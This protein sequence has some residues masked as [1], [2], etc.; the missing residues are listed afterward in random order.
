MDHQDVKPT[1]AVGRTP[2][3]P[4]TLLSDPVWKPPKNSSLKDGETEVL[5]GKGLLDKGT[6]ALKGA[7]ARVGIL[8]PC[9]H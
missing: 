2:E 7:G 3:L 1:I 8:S 4:V 6:A 5:D 9:A